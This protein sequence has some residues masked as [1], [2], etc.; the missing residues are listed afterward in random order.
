MLGRGYRRCLVDSTPRRPKKNLLR[1][2]EQD[3]PGLS[4]RLSR[5]DPAEFLTPILSMNYVRLTCG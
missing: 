3:S 4:A 5:G 2:T 1:L